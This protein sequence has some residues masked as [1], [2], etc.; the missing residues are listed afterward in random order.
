MFFSSLSGVLVVRPEVELILT[1]STSTT[2][3]SACINELIDPITY[4]TENNPT[5]VTV[6]GLPTGVT[7]TYS[8]G[9]LTISGSSSVVATYPY[10]VTTVGG[11]GVASL[12]GTITID[13]NVTIA[14]VSSTASQTVCINDAILPITYQV[15]NGA[16]GAS[17]VAGSVPEGIQGIIM[18]QQKPLPSMGSLQN[19]ELSLISLEL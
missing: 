13:P 16:T 18:L 6:T 4:R 2:F 3:Q 8:G 14:L 12:N 15:G 10:V 19:R 1:S 5:S 11:C 7:S 9:V 17:L